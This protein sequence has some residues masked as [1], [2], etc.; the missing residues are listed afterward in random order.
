MNKRRRAI[1][2][3]LAVAVVLAVGGV[4]SFGAHNLL[5]TRSDWHDQ[6]SE[7]GHNFYP[8]ARFMSTRGGCLDCHSA[9]GFRAKAIGIELTEDEIAAPKDHGVSCIACHTGTD[10]PENMLALR[11][12]G[13][14]ELPNGVMVSAGVSGTCMTCHNSRRGDPEE[15]I[16]G[17]HRGPHHGPQAEML[18]GTGAIQYGEQIGSSVHTLVTF[19]GCL[20]CHKALAPGEGEHGENHLAGHSFQVKWDAGTPEDPRDDIEHLET[21]RRCHPGLD[22]FDRMANGDYD[23]DELVEGVQTEVQGLLDALLAVLPQDE[24]GALS[25]PSDLELTT[26]E[27]R[28]AAYNY[29]FVLEDR[30]MGVHNTA[31]AVNLLRLTYEEF[32]GAPLPGADAIGSP[33]VANR[34][35]ESQSITDFAV[36]WERSPHAVSPEAS[37]E[38]FHGAPGRASCARCHNGNRF[39]PEQVLGEDRLEEDLTVEQVLEQGF[40]HTCATCHESNNPT[41]ILLTYKNGDV[42]L[43]GGQV[44]A[45]GKAGLC[46]SCHNARRGVP[47]EY[48]LGSQR[49]PHGGPQAEMLSGVGGVEYGRAIRSTGHLD[50]VPDKCITCHM[51]DTVPATERGHRQVGGHTLSMEWDGGTPEDHGDD[52]A[53]VGACV[54]CHPDVTP[55]SGFNRVAR[56]DFD[57]DGQIE[58]VQTEIRGLLALVASVLPHNEEGNVSIPSD[59]ELTTVEQRL[60]NYNYGLV[61][62][63]GSYGVHNPLYAAD[64]LRASYEELTGETL[65]PAGP[66]AS[67]SPWDVNGDGVVTIVDLIT[68]AQ[69]F[70]ESVTP[71]IGALISGGLNPDVNGSGMVDIQDIISVSQELGMARPVDVDIPTDA[72]KVW[73]DFERLPLDAS[74]ASVRVHV[75]AT[76][77]ERVAGYALSLKYDPS[78]MRLQTLGNGSVLSRDANAVF[79]ARPEITEAQGSIDRVAAAA[80]GSEATAGDGDALM[81]LTFRVDDLEAPLE[82]LVSLRNIQIANTGADLFRINLGHPT[83]NTL[84]ATWRTVLLQNYPNPFNPETWIPFELAKD[85]EVR[86]EVVSTSGRT[87]RRLDLGWL[88][89]GSYRGRNAAAYWDGQN[90]LGERVSSGVYFYRI[91][92]GDYTAVRKLVILK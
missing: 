54:T 55:E 35:S 40:S 58:G 15:Y 34:P 64:L 39:V 78:V 24:E 12:V 22:T 33:R 61:M 23:G 7:S 70:G 3:S 43:S 79:W 65:K 18:A 81:T 75:R 48:V 67:D 17:S 19:E 51:A 88:D 53:N 8:G 52:V 57:A 45:A 68:V 4:V 2:T 83:F 84:G 49:G 72:A 27:E 69:H 1:R 92:T 80:L 21:C 44:I 89:S 50:A 16:L 91:I 77:Q 85:S 87:I 38:V 66:V 37:E 13:D 31:Y 74:G 59:L 25:I 73:L 32:T 62:N 29:R 6:W 47:E 71:A 5:L 56:E 11:V 86:I 28:T 82:Q 42:T 60:A 9:E 36:G 10:N 46:M 41:D 30:S 26:V 20:T 63:D 76:A 90:E 14:V